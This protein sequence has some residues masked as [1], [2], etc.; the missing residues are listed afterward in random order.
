MGRPGCLTSGQQGVK[1]IGPDGKEIQGATVIIGANAGQT[2]AAQVTKPYVLST[3][4]GTEK[5]RAEVH[6]AGR[7]D[8]DGR[9]PPCDAGPGT[10]LHQGRSTGHILGV[11][12]SPSGGNAI[13]LSRATYKLNREQAAALGTLLGSI[14]ATVMETKVD[15]DNLT[16][17]TTPEAQQTIGQI[18]RLITGQGSGNTFR[19][20]YKP[21]TSARASAC[22]SRPH[23]PPRRCPRARPGRPPRRSP[24]RRPNRDSQARDRR[25]PGERST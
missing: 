3:P 23:R 24:P 22:S 20:E 8:A 2:G 9:G 18:V 11:D 1:V 7:Q 15:G 6:R 4:A 12:D 17:T 14:K 10:E 25:T 19:Y 5:G 16:V 13:T 21:A